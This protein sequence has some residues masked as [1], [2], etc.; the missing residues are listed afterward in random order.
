MTKEQIEQYEYCKKYLAL[1][2]EWK[3]KLP[4][5][6]QQYGCG[7]NAPKLEH[8]LESIHKGMHT[9]VMEAIEE[10]ASKVQILIDE[11]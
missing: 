5:G 6:I 8:T 7:S 3:G 1:I 9:K 4:F 2:K 11:A 10:A